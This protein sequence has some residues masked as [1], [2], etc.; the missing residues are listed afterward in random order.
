MSNRSL[1]YIS[2]HYSILIFVSFFLASSSDKHDQYLILL[3]HSR[4]GHQTKPHFHVAAVPILLS[5]SVLQEELN[6]QDGFE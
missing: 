1:Q 2:E 4:K 6:L 5:V 3:V